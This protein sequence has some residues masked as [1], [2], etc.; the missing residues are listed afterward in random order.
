MITGPW[1]NEEEERLI[2]IIKESNT[3]L[4]ADP[5]ARDAPW[6]VVCQRMNGERTRS[7]IRLKW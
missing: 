1:T 4:G 6:E 5:L 7:Q 2:E 3:A